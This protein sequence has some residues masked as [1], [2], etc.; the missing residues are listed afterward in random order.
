MR[1][2]GGRGGYSHKMGDRFVLFWSGEGNAF[3][4]PAR[5]YLSVSFLNFIH[6]RGFR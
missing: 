1:E 4:M 2:E 5:Y 3:E 6:S